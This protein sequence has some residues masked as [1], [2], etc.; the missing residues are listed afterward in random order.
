MKQPKR[1]DVPLR[2]VN[3]R[4][5]IP[6]IPGRSR[7]DAALTAGVL[8]WTFLACCSPLVD[9][10][11]WWHLRTGQLIWERGAVPQVDWYTFVDF[12]KPW[13]DLHWGFQLLM[14]GLFAAGGATLVILAKAA[15]YTTAVGIAWCTAGRRLSAWIKVL[16]W[17]PSIVC[18]TGRGFERPEM[19]T[20][21]WLALWL[22]V[23]SRLPERPGLIWLLPLVQWV[24]INTHALFVLGFVAGGCFV[25]DY[26]AR[27]AARGRWGLQP[28]DGLPPARHVA[29]AALLAVVVCLINPYFEEG[30][31][32]P[33]VLY[34]KFSVEQA[35]YSVRIGEFQTPLQFVQ[36][37]GLGNVYLLSSLGIWLATA[38]SFVWLAVARRRWSLFRLLMFVAFSH[39]AWKAT[40]NTNLFALV[41]GVVLTAN[42]EDVFTGLTAGDHSRRE[43]LP[44]MIDH[45]RTAASIRWTWVAC[46]V[47]VLLNLA[48]VSGTWD[49]AMGENRPFGFGERP[50]WFAHDACQFAGQ[51]G[52]PDRAFVAH[53]GQAGVY[54]YHNGPERLVFMDARL[55]VCSQQTF[56]LYESIQK[57]M[58]VGNPAW[59]AVVEKDGKLPVVILDSRNSRPQINGLL[60][61]P[62]WRMVFADSAAAVFLDVQLA[63]KLRL[64]KADPSPLMAPPGTR[65]RRPPGN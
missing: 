22:W 41:S 12:D 28:A 63:D 47:V 23:L 57:G 58:A 9:T 40:R 60:S 51:P 32:F 48:V 29:W 8:L 19:L 59:E 31:M 18:I 15:A 27:S 53:N 52:F 26:A 45:S 7:W 64:A 36:R 35:F 21:I 5:T 1:T 25:L 55:E 17:M 44:R 61:S 20:L 39:L 46:F 2:D 50:A 16:L 62:G 4:D 30:L 13:I 38:A 14:A 6:A 54:I 11:F 49:T 3:A 43:S 24:W 37:H 42:L 10:D 33:L 34:R 56:E 65:L